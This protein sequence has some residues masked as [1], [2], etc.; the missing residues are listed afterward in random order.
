[1]PMGSSCVCSAC[2]PQ[3]WILS[4]VF[5]PFTSGH[6][7]IKSLAEEMLAEVSALAWSWSFGG[8]WS[9]EKQFP[10]VPWER[11][12]QPHTASRT[13]IIQL[14][15]ICTKQPLALSSLWPLQCYQQYPDTLPY[16]QKYSHKYSYGSPSC[17]CIPA[18][19]PTKFYAVSAVPSMLQKGRVSGYSSSR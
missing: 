4:P 9:Q 19:H 13:V 6:H 2:C 8:C 12:L 3:P 5:A 11:S 16:Q 14:T 1:M 17:V 7:S 10:P 15:P 18:L